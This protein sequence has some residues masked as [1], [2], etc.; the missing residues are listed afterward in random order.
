MHGVLFLGVGNH[1]SHYRY[2]PFGGASVVMIM[3]LQCVANNL[4]YGVAGLN[5][6][7]FLMDAGHEVSLFHIPSK[8]VWRTDQ[9]VPKSVHRYLEAAENR[10]ESYDSNAPSI[11]MWMQN[12]LAHRIGRGVHV[13]FPFFELTR[14]TDA[15]YHHIEYVDRVFV[16]SSWAKGV[17]NS[18]FPGKEVHV[19]PLGVD[20]TI[21]NEHM[22]EGG[23]VLESDHTVFFNV[24][25]WEIRKGHDVL[26]EAFTRAFDH[27][28][29]VI[30]K[31][32]CNNPFIGS[33]NQQWVGEYRKRLGDRVRIEPRLTDQSAVSKLMVEADCGVF[34]ARAEGWNL[35]LLETLSVGTHAIATNYSAHTEYVDNKNCR[36]IEVTDLDSAEDGIWFH[37]QGEWAKMGEDQIEQLVVHLRDVHRL[38]QIG[39]LG[40]NNAGIETAKRFSWANSAKAFVEGLA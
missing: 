7:K 18:Q 14:F 20:R 28:D 5:L 34:P 22:P 32:A 37:G 25:K 31:M 36:L 15:E 9:E 30:L 4:G 3:N 21:F 27:T 35:D 16:A 39:Q 23:N 10:S 26:L 29:K 40:R 1:Q 12:D 38:K 11:R 17:I 2:I 19:V 24:G 8:G 6:L 33:L 13:G